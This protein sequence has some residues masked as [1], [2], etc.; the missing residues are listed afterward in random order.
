VQVSG[1]KDVQLNLRLSADVNEA[2]ESIANDA[3]TDRTDVVRRALALLM[4]THQAKLEG[5]HLGVV[6]DA[7]KLDTEIV[8]VI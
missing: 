8:G 4:V 1:R 3:E 7:S 6:D 2:L 5:R